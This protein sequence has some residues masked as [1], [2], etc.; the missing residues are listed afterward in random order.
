MADQWIILVEGKE[1][2]PVDL[3][4]LQEWKTEGRV[5]PGNAARRA[6]VDLWKTAADIPGLFQIEQPPIQTWVTAPRSSG[7]GQESAIKNHKV[8][9][10]TTRKILT[11][12]IQI[13]FRGFF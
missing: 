2:G 13:Y 3:T 12:T 6:D 4:T 9:T 10:P 8:V 1:Y 5:L 7:I 11:E